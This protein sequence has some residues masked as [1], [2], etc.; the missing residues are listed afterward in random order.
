MSADPLHPHEHSPNPAPPSSD[1]FLLFIN[2]A[3][4]DKVELQNQLSPS[5]L[6]TLP[7]TE[8]DDCYIVSTGH[9]TTGPF[10]FGGPTLS[11][12]LLAQQIEQEGWQSLEIVSGDGFGTR[13][14]A[15]EVI[16]ETIDRPI[17]LALTINGR[18]LLRQEGLVRLI[19]PN[20]V[21]DALKQV[22]W[23][24]EIRVIGG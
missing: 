7:Q 6:A 8:L 18:P 21:D 19:V 24:A 5:Y 17:L 15:H 13:I 2:K 14:Y 10:Q 1:A 23:I 12:L 11:T 3:T 9:G 20:E 16:D 22:K 4:A